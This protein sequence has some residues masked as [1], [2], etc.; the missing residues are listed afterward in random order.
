MAGLVLAC[1]LLCCSCSRAACVH[2]TPTSYKPSRHIRSAFE[3]LEQLAIDEVQ[4]IFEVLPSQ[5]V[6]QSP[7]QLEHEDRFVLFSTGKYAAHT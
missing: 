5:L 7:K 4:N 1:L 3:A 6:L 2:G